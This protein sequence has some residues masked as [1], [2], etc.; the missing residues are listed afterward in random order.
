[1]HADKRPVTLRVMHRETMHVSSGFKDGNVMAGCL[2]DQCN[3]VPERLD[4]K[5]MSLTKTIRCLLRFLLHRYQHQAAGI[6]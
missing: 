2:L 5:P 1:C 6:A 3:Q 4:A